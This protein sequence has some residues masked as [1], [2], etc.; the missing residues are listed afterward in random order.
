ME[1][2]RLLWLLL[3]L[4]VLAW[5]ETRPADQFFDQKMGDFKAELA[6]AKQEGKKGILLMYELDDCPFCHRMKQTVLNRSEVQDYFRQHFLIFT[7]DTKGDTPMVDFKGKATTEKV[8]SFENRVRAT[9]V[10]AFY[11][12]SGIQMTRYT[13]ATKDAQEF[14]LLGRYVVD[15]VFKDMPFAKYKQQ[16]K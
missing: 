12:L 5:A 13:G 15:D 2:K 8:F 3:L 6:N 1:M 14:L 7:I 10:F 16:A 4:P 9:P 11:D